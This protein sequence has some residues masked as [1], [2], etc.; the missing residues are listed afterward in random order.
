MGWILEEE[1]KGVEGE[2]ARARIF[3]K[4]AAISWGLQFVLWESGLPFLKMFGIFALISAWVFSARAL[5]H[6]VT[7]GIVRLPNET[8]GIAQV[9]VALIG[10]AVPFVYLF[11]H[12]A[13]LSAQILVQ[14]FE[15]YIKSILVW[16][17]LS[18]FVYVVYAAAS[19]FPSFLGVRRYLILAVTVFLIAFVGGQ[20]GFDTDEDGVSSSVERLDPNSI[21]GQTNMAAS[22]V[23]LIILGYGTLLISDLRQ[24]ALSRR[25]GIT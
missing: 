21:E 5:F 15:P 16:L 18:L 19:S 20:G 3:L 14:A 22:Y 24:R 4:L 6:M 11:P 2:P 23:R 12:E 17:P 10:A 25:L 8:Q 9:V 13:D 7:V 1:K